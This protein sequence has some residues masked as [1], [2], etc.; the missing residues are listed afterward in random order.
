MAIM[1]WFIIRPTCCLR[2]CTHHFDGESKPKQTQKKNPK[3]ITRRSL[4]GSVRRGSSISYYIVLA[5]R[6]S[7]ALFSIE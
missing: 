5:S 7:L 6:F 3:K 4:N 1:G 2:V